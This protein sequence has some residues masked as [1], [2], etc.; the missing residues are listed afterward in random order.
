M[1]LAQ[2]HKETSLGTPGHSPNAPTRQETKE[3]VAGITGGSSLFRGKHPGLD[4][5]LDNM[6]KL[7]QKAKGDPDIRGLAF[8]ITK[9]I[10]TDPRT[11]LANRRN[12]DN[13]ADAIYKWGNKTIAYVRDPWMIE[14]IQSPRK[15]LERGFGDCDDHSI[16]YAALMQALG[17]ETRFRVVAMNKKKVLS[18][19]FCN[20]KTKKEGGKTLIR[21]CIQNLVQVFQSNL[22]PITN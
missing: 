19:F 4:G 6:R 9:N 18:T 20:T 5:V 2:S 3:A 16:L 15:T 13:I 14:W 21:H 17:I 7:V 12:F 10:P 11:G 8:E 22:L 1:F